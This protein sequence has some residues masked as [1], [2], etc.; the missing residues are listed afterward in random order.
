[1]KDDTDTE[2]WSISRWPI[3]GT[4]IRTSMPRSRNAGAGPMP[5]RSR[6]AGEWIAPEETMTSFARNSV[7]WPLTRAMTPTQRVPSNNNSAT[8]V[9]AE[10]VRFGRRAAIGEL[11]VDRGAA[12]Q[13][14]RLLVFA[15]RR[16][17]LGAVVRDDLGVDAQF[18]PVKAR[19]EIGGAG[20]GI[21]DLGRH[22]AVGR[23]LPGLAQ[24]D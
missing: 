13:H 18:L 6:C 20:I 19:V 2:G 23:V 14:P 9:L 1:M 17:L 24:Q 11:A 8:W 5:A 12:A 7:S 3:P 16:A 21:E 15:Q 22:L 10:I 4:F